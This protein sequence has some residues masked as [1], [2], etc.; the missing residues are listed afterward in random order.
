VRRGLLLA[1]AG[2]ALLTGCGSPAKIDRH[3]ADTLRAARE[4]LDEAIDTEE[5]IRTDPAEARSR[6]RAVRRRIGE[7]ENAA[8]PVIDE[9]AA[10]DF[11]RYG[12]TN[13]ARALHLPAEEQVEVMAVALGG[14]DH[15]A[16]L[17]GGQKA[18]AFLKDA[19]R[20]VRRIW[21]DLARRLDQARD[22][23]G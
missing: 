5:A 15:D 10:S 3:E 20:D 19:A 1:A 16:A 23:L 18:N 6:V 13:P 14:K 21:P 2:A 11:I 4:R 7:L 9:A 17:P 8:P 12:R 22:D